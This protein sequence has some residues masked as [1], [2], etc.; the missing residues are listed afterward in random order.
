MIL[1]DCAC[2]LV[3]GFSEVLNAEQ[4]A[5]KKRLLA[6]LREL[7]LQGWRHGNLELAA[8][9]RSVSLAN[10]IWFALD[11]LERGEYG[12]C[13]R[14]NQSIGMERLRACPWAVLCLACSE[15]EGPGIATVSRPSSSS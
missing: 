15:A 8:V 5:M 12:K 7:A 14:C 13:A 10:Q 2:R 11:R 4:S 6:G 9:V 1:P 3:Y